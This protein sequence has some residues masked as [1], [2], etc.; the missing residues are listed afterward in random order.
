[1]VDVAGRADQEALHGR[2]AIAL[3]SG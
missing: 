3:V 1:M 2:K